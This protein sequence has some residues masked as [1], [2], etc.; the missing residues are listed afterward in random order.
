MEVD[1]TKYPSSSQIAELYKKSRTL[2]DLLGNQNEVY[3]RGRLFQKGDK[4]VLYDRGAYL[5]VQISNGAT[6]SNGDLVIVKGQYS[7]GNPLRVDEVTLCARCEGNFEEVLDS[8]RYTG[9]S[10]VLDGE[11]RKLLVLRSNVLK[12]VRG[13]LNN[14]GFIE[15]E[16][17]IL[18]Y[19][20]DCAP[21]PTFKTREGSSGHEYHLKICPEEFIKRLAFGFDKIYDLG[22]CFRNGESSEKHSP[23]FTM[24]E[25]YETFSTFEDSMKLTERLIEHVAKEVN[26]TTKVNYRGFEIDFKTSWKRISVDEAS[27]RFYGKS[28][29]ELNE[30]ELRE[31]VGLPEIKLRK[32]DLI[33][34][35]MEK[36]LE[37][38]FIQPTFLTYYPSSSGSPEKNTPNN[39]P[40]KE[41]G[42]AFV[43]R[44]IEIANVGEVN[45]DPRY[46]E[47]HST[48]NVINKFGE[49]KIE[50]N[51]DRDFLYEM[52]FGLPPI[53]GLGIGVDRL[54]MILGG[55]TDI[56]KT[57]AYPFR[58]G[59]K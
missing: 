57:Q 26:G 18:Q 3:V 31:I 54:I 53:S 42:E 6:F 46:L 29:F 25:A 58:N 50:E 5:D 51:L 7:E 1:L 28:V 13:Y 33:R 34:I 9:I 23:E 19:H 44:G 41:Q 47:R 20:P 12:A 36:E 17:P 22:K 11:R 55:V 16:T 48:N 40:T 45:N 56:R 14:Q 35:F 27:K 15:V 43:A 39:P 30:G 32:P 52:S 21:V 24:L 37:H 49:D 10:L 4:I 59:E 2:E 8:N 38:R